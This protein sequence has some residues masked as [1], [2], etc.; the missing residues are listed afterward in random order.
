MTAS[1]IAHID[2]PVHYVDHGGEGTPIVLVHGLGGSHV[3]WSEVA[4]ALT[5]RG[6][7]LAPDLAGFGLTPP[8]GRS[9]AVR[10]NRRLLDRFIAEVAG[11]PAILVGN[12][13][14]GLIAMAQAA[15][16]PGSVEAL[17]LVN[18]AAP[19]VSLLRTSPG[20]VMRLVLPT[21]PVVGPAVLDAYLRRRPVD[22]YVAETL[23]FVCADPTRVSPGH[24]AESAEMARKRRTM[25]WA[26]RAFVDASR[27]IARALVRRGAYDEMA[28]AVTAPTLLIHGDRDDLVD[29]DAIR[30]LADLRPD[31]ELVML[32]GVGHVPQ[33]EVPGVF[34]DV[35]AGWL[36]SLGGRPAAA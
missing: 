34:V 5:A 16:D 7:V 23:E 29:P 33:I 26:S 9:S 1:R 27:S 13:M 14:G 22:E 30:R 3:N 20:A 25:P 35:V 32:D 28:S 8:A 36:A 19:P 11:T 4:G 24:V 17:V 21:A 2:G 10:A 12:S 18:P 6:R 31:W 15:I